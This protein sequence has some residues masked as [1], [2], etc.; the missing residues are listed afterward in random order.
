MGENDAGCP[1]PRPVTSWVVENEIGYC[2]Y[3]VH[4]PGDGVL[5]ATRKYIEKNN[6]AVSLHVERPL[7]T[8]LNA[9]KTAALDKLEVEIRN[10]IRDSNGY[11]TGCD[12]ILYCFRDHIDALPPDLRLNQRPLK[13]GKAEY[14]QFRKRMSK[15]VSN[16]KNKGRE[17][18]CVA[19]ERFPFI[20]SVDK[21]VK[22]RLHWWKLP[23][24]GGD[25]GTEWYYIA[26]SDVQTIWSDARAY[27]LDVARRE[28]QKLNENWYLIPEPFPT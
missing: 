14:D 28:K 10:I 9:I 11:D 18:S 3:S 5:S 20:E 1:C 26:L 27:A 15:H 13:S 12:G 16:Y 25:G 24:R 6:D 23:S 17:I 19:C 21:Y 8:T 7:T 4:A 22:A 2:S